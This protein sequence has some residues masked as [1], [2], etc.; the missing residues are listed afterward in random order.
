MPEYIDREALAEKVAAIRI[1]VC[2]SRSAGKTISITEALN[3]YRD[4]VLKAIREVP[5]AD[6]AEVKRGCWITTDNKGLERIV[7]CSV[8]HSKDYYPP[9]R[10]NEIRYPN[11]CPDCGAVIHSGKMLKE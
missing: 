2:L 6:V 5:A 3:F 11:Y 10:F 8:C 4:A 9:C 7:E 1:Y